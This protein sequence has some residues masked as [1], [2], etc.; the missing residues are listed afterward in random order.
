MEGICGHRRKERRR[1]RRGERK[2]KKERKE[3]RMEGE[4][5]EDPDL[6]GSVVNPYYPSDHKFKSSLGNTARP[7]L[8]IKLELGLLTL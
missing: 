6:P 2:I 8:K 7:C 1:K 5:K 3:G 4:E